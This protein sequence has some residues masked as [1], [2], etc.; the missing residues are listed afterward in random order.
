[1][2]SMSNLSIPTPVRSSKN[3]G[4]NGVNAGQSES[5]LSVMA[6]S[7]SNV[8]AK[9]NKAAVVVVAEYM[10]LPTLVT[11][12]ISCKF[13]EVLFPSHPSLLKDGSNG[14]ALLCLCLLWTSRHWWWSVAYI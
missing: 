7:V 4:G 2:A 5:A 12:N 11:R 1:M 6:M 8:H 9:D 13:R 3:K 10:D 14:D